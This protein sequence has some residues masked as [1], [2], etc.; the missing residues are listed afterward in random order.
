MDIYSRHDCPHA[1]LT[2]L[3]PHAW[4]TRRDF[5]QIGIEMKYDVL[6]DYLVETAGDSIRGVGAGDEKVN[7]R[8]EA[9]LCD[10][11][12]RYVCGVEGDEG[13]DF[14]KVAEGDVLYIYNGK[15]YEKQ[16]DEMQLHAIVKRVMDRLGI[17]IVY[18]RNSHEK[19]ANECWQ[20]L[21][22]DERCVFRPD[23]RYIVFTNGVLDVTTGVLAPHDIKFE[24]DVV[25]DI[26]YR[27][28]FHTA[29]WDKL[30]EETIPD[31][32]MRG[33]FQQFCGAF[34]ADRTRYKIEY[35]CLMVG[36][37]RNGK[38]VVC[39][40]IA[41]V[42]GRDLISNYSPEQLFR[43]QQSMYN[44]ADINGK[45][46]NYADDVS[47][48]DFSGGEFKQFT[49]G[50]RFMA[51]HIYGR[52]FV[53]TKVPLM[54]CCVNEIPPTTD[55]TNG[56]Y[57]RL[58]PIVCPNQ[59]ADADVDIELPNKLATEEVRSSIFNWILEGYRS[60]VEASGKIAI[61]ESIKTMKANIKEDSN[62]ARR[63]M[64]ESGFISVVPAGPSDVRW[65]S[66]KE[67]MSNYIS[68]CKDYSEMP[69]T[70]KAV[71]KLFKEMGCAMEKRRDTTWYCVG[72]EGVDN[73]IR[74][75]YTPNL[76]PSIP[77]DLPF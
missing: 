2:T 52:P 25:L 18:R 20:G 66:L 12:E 9:E 6:V 14:F 33:A 32:G 15:Y 31:G 7:K 61:S 35:I 29:I 16:R 17:G 27:K 44:L 38:S 49:S 19:I 73:I 4:T 76:G 43:G 10:A 23:R 72:V 3:L 75:T 24:T 48:K 46:G 58:L 57:R 62:S 70:A 50:A 1:V 59:V 64:R 63:W 54:M 28:G 40:A 51:R 65:K 71:S 60:L 37:G 55:D 30:I 5:C 74:E 39:Q 47:N 56:Y 53:V 68:Y 13:N 34:L 26:K 42:F 45:L 22:T 8:K 69:K 41:D 11:F 67:L 21:M 36:T 77:D